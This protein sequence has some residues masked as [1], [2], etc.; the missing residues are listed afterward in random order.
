ME[1][2]LN[3]SNRKTR[4]RKLVDVELGFFSKNA[5]KK[6]KREDKPIFEN[7]LTLKK[8]RK[9]KNTTD[10][11][12][13]PESPSSEDSKENK[14]PQTKSLKQK[15]KSDASK[16]KRKGKTSTAKKEI[17]KDEAPASPNILDQ[18][19]VEASRKPESPHKI[20]FKKEKK[21]KAP[22]TKSEQVVKFIVFSL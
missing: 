14:N 6:E 22:N 8:E 5:E 12:R 13:C 15:S 7:K 18:I 20:V 2:C 3:N 9:Q 17:V 10:D 4:K 1:F 11:D 21:T 16:T 19:R